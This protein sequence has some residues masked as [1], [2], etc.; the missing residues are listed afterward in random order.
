MGEPIDQA[1]LRERIAEV[2]RA[3]PSALIAD[4]PAIHPGVHGE[5]HRYH[6][7]CALCH[8]EADTLAA[9]VLP[10]VEQAVAEQTAQL[11]AEAEQLRDR[12]EWL[13]EQL[14]HAR[15]QTAAA[16]AAALKTTAN[17]DKRR[18][19][20]EAERDQYAAEVEHLR[21]VRDAGDETARRFLAQRQEMAAERY[22][23]QE[24]GRRAEADRDHL[25]K[26]VE[27]LEACYGE[28]AADALKH[29]GCHM[30]LGS[31]LNRAEAAEAER[32]RL[33]AYVDQYRASRKR[34]MDAAYEDRHCAVDFAAQ[35]SRVRA[36]HVRDEDA[37]YC[38]VCS[39]HGDI[40]WPC[41]TIAAIDD[42]GE[43]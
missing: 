20:A 8:G 1:G 21:S 13:T 40:N 23:W 2:L 22:E 39:N 32:D 6:A 31:V 14:A 29:R 41:A 5:T 18:A 36:L 7:G 24:R 38:T 10:L 27:A 26:K 34:W 4:Y 19:E 33:A 43:A 17:H 30:R 9:A 42:T 12:G 35:L 16:T 11:R 37:N 28:V 3:T 25:A 15:Q